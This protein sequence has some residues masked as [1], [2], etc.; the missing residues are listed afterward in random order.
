MSR[1]HAFRSKL[2]INLLCC[3]FLLQYYFLQYIEDELFVFVVTFKCQLHKR[4]KHTQTI[5]HQ[6]STSCLGGFDHFAGLELKRFK[7]FFISAIGLMVTS[8]GILASISP[9][10][11]FSILQIDKTTTLLEYHY[12]MMS[13]FYARG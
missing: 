9:C 8:L 11:Y 12:S 7:I 13:C 1:L 4:V 2:N 10:I 3:W 5:C 6:Q